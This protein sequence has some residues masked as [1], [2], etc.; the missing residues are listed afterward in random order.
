MKR[1]L[2]AILIVVLAAFAAALGGCVVKK[3]TGELTEKTYSVDAID[4]FSVENLS[5]QKT[6][7][8]F[9]PTVVFVNDGGER[10]ITVSM[11][12]SMF[13]TVTPRQ[14]E[15]KFVLSGKSNYVYLTDYDVKIVVKNCVLTKIGLHGAA[16]GTADS[17]SLGENVGLE[18][19]G[20]ARFVAED[21]ACHSFRLNA[22]GASNAVFRSVV[23]STMKTDLSGASAF[24]ADLVTVTDS[25]DAEGS[26]GSEYSFTAGGAQTISVDLSGASRFHALAFVVTDAATIDL[27]G[28]SSLK[29]TVNGTLDGS[30]S[31][32]SSVEYRGSAT[33]DVNKSGGSTVRNV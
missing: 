17:A 8:S 19:S 31:G 2:P 24:R 3:Q 30:A 25:I 23:C 15:K 29:L 14:T 27:S 22:S 26:G 13:D 9:G 33:A 1:I 28:A 5:L 32:A 12:K 11:Q 18:L 4:S 20:A 7:G 10:E 16:Q 6:D 21:V